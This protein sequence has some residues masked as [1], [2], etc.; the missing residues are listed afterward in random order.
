[1]SNNRPP[2]APRRSR[3]RVGFAAAS[4]AVLSV[5]ATACGD[6]TDQARADD[7][8]PPARWTLEQDLR[9]GSLDGEDALSQVG[10]VVL[11]PDGRIV[12]SLS[13]ERR[14]VV[15]AP[16]GARVDSV[17]R[18][19]EG[20]GEFL[21]LSYLD[22]VGDTLWVYD[23]R[24]GRLSF[25]DV[26]GE[27]V[28]DQRV[29]EVDGLDEDER[30]MFGTLLADGRA[31]MVTSAG[32]ESE[33]EGTDHP[34]PLVAVPR[35][36]GAPDT[37]AIRYTAHDRAMFISGTPDNITRV[38]VFRQVFSDVTVWTATPDGRALVLVD[39]RPAE[40]PGPASWRLTRVGIE[41]DTA[42]SVDVPY[43]PVPVDPARVDS[44]VARYSEGRRSESEIRGVL[45]LP[46]F[47]P[48]VSDV[49]AADDG[50]IW[51]AREDRPEHA[52]T[53]EVFDAAGRLLAHAETPAGFTA[54]Y[55]TGDA[56]WGVETDEL[57]V[58]YVVRYRVVR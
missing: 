53:W 47:L 50:A 13:Q 3:P 1:M 49:V 43:E 54:H 35:Q 46:D 4:L 41:G 24:Q 40:G 37:L 29:P 27:H 45:F 44:I 10:R 14:V 26:A 57:D 33:R 2:L 5:S 15:F 20:P 48:P 22:F 34:F 28:G 32:F 16:D 17:G 12:I 18:A 21:A 52:V 23:A 7:S 51:V 9:I 55:A 19:G 58:P 56:L 31:V 8:Q 11:G 6:A 36:G 38:E 42:F 25:F 39:R 30:V